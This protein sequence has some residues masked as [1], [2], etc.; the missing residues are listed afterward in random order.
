MAEFRA[1]KRVEHTRCCSET[2][3]HINTLDAQHSSMAG[4]G[5]LLLMS[6]CT[7]RETEAQKGALEVTE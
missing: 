4:G 1:G 3:E 6:C 2:P 5:G 7:D